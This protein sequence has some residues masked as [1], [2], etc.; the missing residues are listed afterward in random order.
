MSSQESSKIRKDTIK[1]TQK[2]GDILT[3]EKIFRSGAP[4]VKLP[5]K[6]WEAPLCMFPS[7]FLASWRAIF[8]NRSRGS[9]QQKAASL[10]DFYLTR[11]CLTS[12]L[13]FLQCVF[14]LTSIL[15]NRFDESILKHEIKYAG[16]LESPI[17][18]NL[19]RRDVRNLFLAQVYLRDRRQEIMRILCFPP[20][21]RMNK[22]DFWKG[23][24]NSL[25]DSLIRLG[26]R[27]IFSLMSIAELSWVELSWGF[28]PVGTMR[29]P[30]TQRK[31][32][33]I[34]V[35]FFGPTN[36]RNS[37]KTWWTGIIMDYSENQNPPSDANPWENFLADFKTL[38]KVLFVFHL[39]SAY[40]LHRHLR[41]WISLWQHCYCRLC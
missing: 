38:L 8:R 13:H 39:L 16:N 2:N 25:S 19:S 21:E 34:R 4:P 33:P 23:A 27:N 18:Q 9:K 11:K 37:G 26:K 20:R 5:A 1:R 41:Q 35:S 32:D 12:N 24:G 30:R 14:M 29:M 36:C 22:I 7:F 31:G 6:I 15:L 40:E 28:Y 10:H 3:N 17:W